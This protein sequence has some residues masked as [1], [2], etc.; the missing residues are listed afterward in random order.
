MATHSTTVRF[1]AHDLE[2][3]SVIQA[4]LGGDRTGVL[5][6]LIHERRR[7]IELAKA[8]AASVSKKRQPGG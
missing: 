5:R 7:A 3:L 4:E 1:T 8:R 6:V 2:A